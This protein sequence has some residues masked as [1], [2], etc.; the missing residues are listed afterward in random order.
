M[1]PSI[2]SIVPPIVAI[3]IS[4]WTKQTYLSLLIALWSGAL[5][6]SGDPLTGTLNTLNMIS[7]VFKDEDNTR[8]IMF[9]ALMGGLLLMMQKSGGVAGFLTWISNHLELMTQKNARKVRLWAYFT[10]VF[11]FIETTISSLV[12]GTVF[13]PLA[14]QHKVSREA[15]SYI[16]DTTSAPTSVLLPFNAW[17]AFIMGLLAKQGI[18]DGFSVL[19]LCIPLN[20]Y[21]LLSLISCFLFAYFNLEF[22]PMKT[23]GDRVRNGQILSDHAKPLISDELSMV[24]PIDHVPHRAINMILP[25]FTM[26]LSMPIA[27]IYTGWP[28]LQTIPHLQIDQ[29]SLFKLTFLA[30]SKGSGSFSVLIAIV[31][32]LLVSMCMY[33]IQGIFKISEMME[34]IL[35][36]ISELMPLALLM[37]FA[38]AMSSL[39]KELGTGI[40]VAQI[41]KNTL[42]PVI[43]PALI[44]II[45]AMTSFATGTSWGTFSILIPIAVPLANALID[46]SAT[47]PIGQNYLYLMIAAVLGGGVF[48]DHTSPISDTTIVSSMASASD[49][50]DHVKTQ[51]PYA[52]IVASISC[53]LYLIFAFIFE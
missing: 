27:L 20:F 3:I 23:A 12:V 14:D 32:A 29:T 21:A 49:H 46:P 44:F 25:I 26:I 37:V 9:S 39:C 6:L 4:L 8:T 7:N 15:L 28:K 16:A 2:L 5:I 17:G 40:Y 33:R 31:S 18:S 11:I 24:Q 30:L 22:G 45:A 48:G 19:M 50:L 35:K 53:L 42:P 13:R 10:G 52:L 47:D 38:F 51:L 34:L 41:F 1:T 36:G 43:C